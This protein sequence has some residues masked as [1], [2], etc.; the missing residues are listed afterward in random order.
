[1]VCGILMKLDKHYWAEASATAVYLRNRLP[2]SAVKIMTPYEV[3]YKP[4]ISHLQPFG[5]KCYVYIPEERHLPGSKLLLPRRNVVFL[6]ASYYYLVQRLG[7][8]LDTL[9]HNLFIR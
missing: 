5:N 7:I 2:Y 1:M 3:L 4:K 6:E 9:T 8:S